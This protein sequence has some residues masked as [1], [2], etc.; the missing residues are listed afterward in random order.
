MVTMS[1]INK[2]FNTDA[3]KGDV[4]AFATSFLILNQIMSEL[5]KTPSDLEI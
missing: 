3:K 2:H 1:D 5:K 4:K